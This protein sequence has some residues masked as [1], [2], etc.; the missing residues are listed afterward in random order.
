MVPCYDAIMQPMVNMTI[1]DV[2]MLHILSDNPRL[3]C[4]PSHMRNPE[5]HTGK[6]NPGNVCKRTLSSQAYAWKAIQYHARCREPLNTMI[7]NRSMIQ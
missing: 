5:F 2:R 6:H 7:W 4:R 3:P 1:A